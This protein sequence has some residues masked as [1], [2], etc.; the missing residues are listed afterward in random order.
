MD[1]GNSYFKDT[2][3]RGRWLTEQGIQFL[4]L[5]LAGGQ[6]GPRQGA[7]VM[8]GGAGEARQRARL[9]LEAI[10]AKVHGE[11]CV[12]FLETAAAAHFAKMVHAG[13]EYAL[14]QLLSEMFDLIQRT[15]ILTDVESRNASEAWYA[16][17]FNGYLMEITA[18]A[19]EPEETR[20]PRPLLEQ[21]LEAARQDALGEWVAR[22]AL[23]LQVS[24]PTMDAAAGTLT[25][26]T[27][28]RQRAL[29]AT[30]NRHPVGR[31]GNDTQ[32]VMDQLRGAL[33]AAMI[34][35]Y[36]QGL[37]LLSAASEHHGLN[38]KLDD[39]ARAWKGCTRLRTTLLDDIAAA[40]RTTP[41]LPDLLS[42]EDLSEKVM[43]G[44]EYLRRA[45]WRAHELETTTPALLASLDYLDSNR[46]AWLP[47]NLIQVPGAPP[48]EVRMEQAC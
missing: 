26:A 13:I 46:R 39:L 9:M 15:S 23:E 40:L 25:I 14:L 42:D 24:I 28:E 41:D 47:V 38:F 27:R 32:S 16:S 3:Q 37:A 8:A 17:V 35:T 31:F 21:K 19:F 6:D 34:I 11:P 10:A 30:P 20:M 48:A 7:I 44:Q 12:S 22:S 18:R 43:A 45:V 2:A 33:H 1:A 36:A 4:G 29:I 5:G